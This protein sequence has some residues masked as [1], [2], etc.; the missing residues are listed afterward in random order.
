MLAKAIF[1]ASVI[2]IGSVA[3]DRINAD[4]HLWSAACSGGAKAGHAC[5]ELGAGSGAYADFS[6]DHAVRDSAVFSWKKHFLGVTCPSDEDVV[7]IARANKRSIW[8]S[9]ADS[10]GCCHVNFANGEDAPETADST[11]L[12]A[13]P[14]HTYTIPA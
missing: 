5:F 12:T 4:D 13:C 11:Q 3:G 9:A 2:L 10:A 8:V 7:K 14:G 6:I 1:L